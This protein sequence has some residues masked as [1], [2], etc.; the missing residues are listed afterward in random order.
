M[1]AQPRSAQGLVLALVTLFF[2]KVDTQEKFE[3]S[4]FN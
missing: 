2:V 3:F 4:K 1:V